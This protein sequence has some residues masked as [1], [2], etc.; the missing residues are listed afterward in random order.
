MGEREPD[1]GNITM[2]GDVD[3]RWTKKQENKNKK[4]RERHA[5]ATQK[6]VKGELKIEGRE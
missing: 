3:Q 4:H 1:G 5:R 6:N 2:Q